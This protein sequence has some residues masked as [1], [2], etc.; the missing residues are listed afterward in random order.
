VNSPIEKSVVLVGAG[1][2]HLVFVKRFGMMPMP[3][4]AVTLVSE[5]ATIPYSAMVPGHLGGDYSCEDITIDL[6]RLCQASQVR[7]VAQRVEQLDPR[8]R[9]VLFAG[10]PPLHYDVLSL[11]LGSLP[12]IPA[13]LANAEASFA[14]RPLAAMTQTLDALD[15]ELRERPR[16]FQFVI[17]GGGASGCELAL[18]IHKR[19]GQYPGFRLTLLQGDARLVPLFPPGTAR[20][21]ERAFAGRGIGLRVNT[22]VIGGQQGS[23]LLEGGE[24]VPFDAVLWATQ[25]AAPGLIR[26][27]SLTVDAG[28][29]LKVLPTL[30]F[31]G[32]PAPAIASHSTPTLPCPATAST[33]FGKARSCSTTS[34]L[35]SRSN[36]C[37][38]SSRNASA[39][40]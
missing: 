3:G 30:Q 14:M 21:F 39:C 29:F 26:A 5:A 4:V 6:V 8:G 23:L 37:A 15:C 13:D 19:L 32:N 2:A 9:Q 11:G 31:T 34:N 17:V 27:S 20:A 33:R 18:A 16:P 36:V 25:G 10:R 1:N 22:R 7:F 40:A 24:S 28:G 12:A 35:F 38:R